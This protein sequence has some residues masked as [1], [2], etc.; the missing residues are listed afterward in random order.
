MSAALPPIVDW[1]G[2]CPIMHGERAELDPQHR[3]ACLC[4]EY[5]YYLMCPESLSGGLGSI[6]LALDA[7]ID[8]PG[9]E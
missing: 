8:V 4:G 3:E 1:I 7:A 6:T 5:D 2:D 9:S